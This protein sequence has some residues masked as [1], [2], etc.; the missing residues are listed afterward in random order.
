MTR[1]DRPPPAARP[2]RDP[3]LSAVGG[4]GGAAPGPGRQ[5]RPLP[6]E[7]AVHLQVAEYLRKVGLGPGALAAHIRNER[8]GT[9][10]KIE[11]HRMGILPGIP[12]FVVVYNGRCG[13]IELKRPGW[14]RAKARTHKYTAHELRQAEAQ[15]LLK[16]A[17]CWVE[18]CESL[19]EFLGA[20]R[21]HKVPLRETKIETPVITALRNALTQTELEADAAGSYTHAVREI[22]RLVQIGDDLPPLHAHLFSP[23]RRG[24]S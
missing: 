13:F 5:R 24:R 23:R 6:S 2:G 15:R 7:R 12:D 17:G 3:A 9:W 11:A 4:R 22:G 20:L 10:Q 21:R 8:T 14:S 19:G 1:T 16:L 18:T